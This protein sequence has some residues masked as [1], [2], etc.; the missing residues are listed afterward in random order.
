MNRPEIII[1]SC[2]ERTETA[3][4]EIAE[5]QG[6]VHIIR[7]EPFSESIWQTYILAM[8]I[9]QKW[10]PVIDADVL[11]YDGVI[12]TAIEELEKKSKN[13]FCLDGKTLDKIL[14]KGR[15][16]GVHIYRTEL[17]DIAINFIEETHIKPETNVRNLMTE[18]GYGTWAGGGIVFG[19]HDY[20]Q[21]YC[22]LWRK[23]CCQAWK[24]R[25]MISR[26]NIYERWAE[27]SKHDNDY[28]VV[29][30]ANDFSN[31]NLNPEK[32]IIDKKNDFNAAENI[33]FLGL[34]EKGEM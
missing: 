29:K 16:A 3:C 15:R 21:Y 4:A 11:L 7:A 34:E 8:D 1:R 24:I 25:G 22:D 17:L 27:Y 5:R 13:T 28:V 19:R 12:N 31:D 32:I 23:A 30:A 10:T 33:E 14:L 26:E 18:M 20:E 2:G 9:G 6:R